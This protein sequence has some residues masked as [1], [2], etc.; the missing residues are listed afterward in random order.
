MDGKKTQFPLRPHGAQMHAIDPDAVSAEVARHT[1]GQ[2]NETAFAG[3]VVDQMRH[4]E[5]QGNAANIDDDAAFLFNHMRDDRF[6][7]PESPVKISIENAPEL[8]EIHLL[9]RS[10]RV[11]SGVIYKDIDAPEFLHHLFYG[12]LCLVAFGD[13]EL[14]LK[15]RLDRPGGFGEITDSSRHFG[16]AP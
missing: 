10:S 8:I 11:N 1:P 7:A 9:D 3:G 15:G 4:T 14:D 13:I 6:R 16:P 12:A 2:S 5:P